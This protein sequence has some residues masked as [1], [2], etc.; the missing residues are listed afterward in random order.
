M[1]RKRKKLTQK[2]KLLHH[3]KR[4]GVITSLT[5]Y[6]KFGITQ[7]AA[8]IKEMEDYQGVKIRRKPVKAGTARIIQYSLDMEKA[9]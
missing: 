6:T 2:E 1:K 5:A 9:G 7:L 3:F 4:G 8:R